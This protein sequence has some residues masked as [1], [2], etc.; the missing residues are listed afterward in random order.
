MFAISLPIVVGLAGWPWVRDS[1]GTSARSCARATK[2]AMTRSSVGSITCLRASFSISA[3]EVL[4][5][6]SEVQAK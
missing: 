3:C 5:M 4:L 1:I 2:R 6:S